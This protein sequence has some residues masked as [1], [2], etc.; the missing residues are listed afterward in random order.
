[1]KKIIRKIRQKVSLLLKE[2]SI[3]EILKWPTQLKEVTQRLSHMFIGIMHGRMVNMMLQANQIILPIHQITMRTSKTCISIIGSQ[4]STIRTT[5]HSSEKT[6]IGW[7]LTDSEIMIGVMNH[8][9]INKRSHKENTTKI[10]HL[11]SEKTLIGWSLMGSETMIG[12]MNHLWISITRNRESTTRLTHLNSEKILTG[13]IL[14]DS[15]NMIGA[16]NLKHA[17]HHLRPYSNHLMIQV[18]ST[19]Q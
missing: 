17:L 4:E 7:S 12:A 6:Q 2:D 19:L 10:T 5:H 18:W 9:W 3:R 16:M 13:S 1:M 8:L 15:G 14:T 11:N